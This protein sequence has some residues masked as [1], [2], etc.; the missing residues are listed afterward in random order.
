MFCT[1]VLFIR[2]GA[3]VCGIS[4]PGVSLRSAPGYELVGLSARY[5]V[6]NMSLQ[7]SDEPKNLC[8]KKGLAVYN[9]KH[10]RNR[11]VFRLSEVGLIFLKNVL[12]NTRIGTKL[13]EIG[14]RKCDLTYVKRVYTTTNSHFFRPTE[15]L[16][17]YISAGRYGQNALRQR[18]YG[19]VGE[20]KTVLQK[21]SRYLCEK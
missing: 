17:I 11:P 15:V 3:V 19:L 8:V 5:L 21:I 20:Q 16:I 6:C 2:K 1:E 13:V 9:L 12:T 18:E 4:K 7:M 10:D 14:T